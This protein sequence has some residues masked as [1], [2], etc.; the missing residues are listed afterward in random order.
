MDALKDTFDVRSYAELSGIMRFILK[1]AEDPPFI[2]RAETI[3]AGRILR[4]YDPI[5][6]QFHMYR[7]VEDTKVMA[8]R[9]TGTLWMNDSSMELTA[10]APAVEHAHG[11]VL[12]SGLGLGLF[13]ALVAT[14]PNVD[15]VTVIEREQKIINLVYPQLSRRLS[16]EV[17][18]D[19]L[20]HYLK[21]TRRKYDF[22][23]IDIWP[24]IL[25]PIRE[26]D[27]VRALAEKRLRPGGEVRVWLQELVE[28]VR[29]SLPAGP[30]KPA[31]FSTHEPCLVCGK[32]LR[33]DYA[34]L[35]LD[36]ADGLGLSELWR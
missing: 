11:R 23:Y 28:R 13:V 17:I 31:G 8:L 16:F 19:D 35:C 21:R 30:I 12:T 27:G 32:T 6:G 29:G 3:P 26:M 2:L 9:E 20:H 36:C 1:D 24:D 5:K 7:S 25:A 33:H 14:K 18:C 4:H 22:M 34:G 15:S 10:I